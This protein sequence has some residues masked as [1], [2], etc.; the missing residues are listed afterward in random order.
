M[1]EESVMLQQYGST[2]DSITLYVSGIVSARKTEIWLWPLSRENKWVDLNEAQDLGYLTFR[3]EGTNGEITVYFD[4]AAGVDDYKVWDFRCSDVGAY[5][6]TTDVLHALIG[7]SYQNGQEKTSG[8]PVDVTWK[9]FD[10][11][12]RYAMWMSSSMIGELSSGLY[13]FTEDDIGKDIY[14]DY[15][16]KPVRVMLH[17]AN[18]LTKDELLHKSDLE[19]ELDTILSNVYSGAPFA[20]KLFRDRIRYVFDYW[21]MR[22]YSV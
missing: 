17:V 18:S 9:D 19:D 4:N 12:N 14:A 21:W 11:I 20:A 16:A 2:P 7:F 10:S 3:S 1:A 13:S 22:V 5:T 6:K 8:E 15:L